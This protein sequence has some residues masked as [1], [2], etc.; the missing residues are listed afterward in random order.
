MKENIWFALVHVEPGNDNQDLGKAKGAFVNVAYV[1]PSKEQFMEIISTSFSEFNF[2]VLEIDDVERASEMTLDN[3][4]NAEK[5]LLLDRIENG[6]E[7]TWG[8]F[9]TYMES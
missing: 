2:K 9:H 5:L 3:A 4:D 6:L 1:A 7:M 8:D